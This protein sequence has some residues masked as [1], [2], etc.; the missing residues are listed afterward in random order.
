MTTTR[1]LLLVLYAVGMGVGQILFKV[2]A[3]AV[4]REPGGGGLVA[5]LALSPPFL[6]AIV[7]YAALTV[8][9]VWILTKVPL[10]YAYPFNALAF[11]ATPLL[12]ALV[13]HERI[14]PGY[15]VGT[16]LLVGGLLVIT[17]S[18]RP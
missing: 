3:A 16:A 18:A 10:V 6:A 12:A 17:L 2:A 15:L 7:L 11:M 9:W 4:E 13:L 14:T 8:F 1:L 5:R